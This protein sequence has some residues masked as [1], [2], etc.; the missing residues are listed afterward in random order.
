MRNVCSQKKATATPQAID[1]LSG[2]ILIGLYTQQVF[3]DFKGKPSYIQDASLT[4][5]AIG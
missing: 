2:G 1:L 5:S 3:D 4:F